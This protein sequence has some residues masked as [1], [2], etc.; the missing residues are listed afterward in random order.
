[1]QLD[2][3]LNCVL[4][5]VI[6]RNHSQG[7]YGW[8]LGCFAFFSN[9]HSATVTV[10]L[11][12]GRRVSLRPENSYDLVL[13]IWNGKVEQLESNTCILKKAFGCITQHVDLKFPTRD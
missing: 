7:S 10:T 4:N 12:T 1:M 3:F 8:T 9:T 2:I 13:S 11:G 6:L 5:S